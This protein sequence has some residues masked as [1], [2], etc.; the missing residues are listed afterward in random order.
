MCG[1]VEDIRH[2]WF[3]ISRAF[4]VGEIS[5][6]GSFRFR[7]CEVD[8][9]AKIV[10]LSMWDYLEKSVRFGWLKTVFIKKIPLLQN[11]ERSYRSLYETLMY[12]ANAILP[13]VAMMASR[14][15]QKLYGLK[16]Y[17]IIDTTI[18]LRRSCICAA[19]KVY[20]KFRNM[21]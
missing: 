14:R 16:V 7:G 13:Q 5:I 8:V 2:F 1:K 10:E 15:K 19:H 6:G 3:E 9:G 21:K 17:H 18:M 12:L 20:N 4:K 11:K